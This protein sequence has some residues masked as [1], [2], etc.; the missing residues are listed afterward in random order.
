MGGMDKCE[1]LARCMRLSRQ[2]LKDALSPLVSEG[3]I[4]KIKSENPLIAD[5]FYK[6]TSKG[7]QFIELM[8]IAFQYV[9]VEKSD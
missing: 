1:D 2:G 6:I 5:E 8:E 7:E 4:K 3:L 9:D